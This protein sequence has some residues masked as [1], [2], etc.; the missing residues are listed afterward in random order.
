M[1]L[2]MSNVCRKNAQTHYTWADFWKLTTTNPWTF[3][4]GGKVGATRDV[5]KQ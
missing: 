3:T 2:H 1:K 4:L 5:V